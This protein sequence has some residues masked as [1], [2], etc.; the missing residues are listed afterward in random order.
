MKALSIHPYY[1]CAIVT[2]CKSI[3]VRS[4]RTDYRGDLVICSTQKKF[5]GTVPGH[6]LGVVTLE[7]VVPLEKKH[8]KDALMEPSDYAPGLYAWKLTYNRLIVPVPV[9]GKL[10]LWEYGGPLEYIPEEEWI[11]PDGA[12]D[13]DG[14]G[15][16]E[17][18]WKPIMT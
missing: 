1:A 12:D 17:K 9:K 13:D 2:G 7:D 16:V 11:L 8:M 6:A 15:W 5:H 14:G 3:E 4:W 18:Y 10:S